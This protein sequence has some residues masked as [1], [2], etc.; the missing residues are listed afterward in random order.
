VKESG[1]PREE[2]F[3]TTKIWPHMLHPD[4]VELSLDQ[5]LQQLDVEHIDLLLAHWPVSFKSRGR[6]ALE[7]ANLMKGASWEDRGM[8]GSKEC[9]VL[10]WEFCSERIARQTGMQLTS[11]HVGVEC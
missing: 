10:E 7:K 9:P 3:I 2:I 1:I 8:V 11:R 6:E 5:S 4:H